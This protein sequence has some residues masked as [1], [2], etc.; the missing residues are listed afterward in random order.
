MFALAALICFLLALFGAHVGT[1][2]L[3]VLGFVF[4]AAHLLVGLWP[5]GG[6]PW[7]RPPA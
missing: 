6:P 2:D 7:R 5:F 1:V 3:P 4:V